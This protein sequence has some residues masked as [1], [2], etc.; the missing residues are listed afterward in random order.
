MEIKSK[1]N[2]KIYRYENTI[3]RT[4]TLDKEMYQKLYAKAKA[5]DITVSQL[6]RK[7]I[8]EYLTKQGM[9]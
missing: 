3:V 2:N 8:K 7:L 6:V 4:F 1:I 5:E 9:L